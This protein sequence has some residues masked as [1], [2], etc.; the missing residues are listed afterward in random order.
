MILPNNDLTDN[1]LTVWRMIVFSPVLVFLVFDKL[2]KV[3]KLH[4]LMLS[5]N[6]T[7]GFSDSSL[8]AVDKI[9]VIK[10]L[11]SSKGLIQLSR[12]STAA[13]MT[14]ASFL[15]LGAPCNDLYHLVVSCALTDQEMNCS[16]LLSSNIFVQ[17]HFSDWTLWCH[18]QP[19]FT[20]TSHV[21]ST[22]NHEN[23]LSL[24]QLYRKSP[25]EKMLTDYWDD[26]L[27]G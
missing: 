16:V 19:L 27:V 10:S 21:W 22:G 12:T 24:I 3:L 25:S 4:L 6:L 1:D 23:G 14:A 17:L 2:E 13:S 26:Y 5:W 15:T 20:V 7:S 11:L 8:V 9:Q 18:Q